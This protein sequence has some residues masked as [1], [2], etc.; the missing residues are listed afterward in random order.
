[1]KVAQR[2]RAGVLMPGLVDDR[3]ADPSSIFR[4]VALLAFPFG[5]RTTMSRPCRRRSMASSSVS[6]AP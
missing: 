4:A 1:M 6:A 3:G 5:P 2:V